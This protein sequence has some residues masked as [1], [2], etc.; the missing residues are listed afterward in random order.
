MSIDRL[1]RLNALMKREIAESLFEV[2]SAERFDLAAVTITHVITNRDLR[3][4]RVLVSIRGH[5]AERSRMLDALRR[6]R[7]E[8]QS[9]INRDLTLKYTPRLTFDLDLSI[10]RGDRVLGLLAHMAD[11]QPEGPP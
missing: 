9:R 2:M 3:S 1:T 11:A 8:I 6:H 5:A 4:A 7:G 10:E